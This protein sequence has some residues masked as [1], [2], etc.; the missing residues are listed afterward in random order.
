MRDDL[1]GRRRLDLKFDVA[2]LVDFRGWVDANTVCLPGSKYPAQV[3]S[4][5]SK[6]LF[7]SRQGAAPFRRSTWKAVLDVGKVEDWLAENRAQ[8]R[9]DSTLYNYACCILQASRFCFARLGLPLP[10]GYLDYMQ[11]KLRVLRRRRVNEEMFRLGQA[12]E[13]GPEDLRPLCRAVLRNSSCDDRMLQAVRAARDFLCHEVDCISSGDFLFAM[14]YAL[15]HSMVGSA[16]RP[17][18]LYTLSAEAMQSPAAGPWDG[19]TAVLLK[20]PLHKTAAHMGPC[21]LVVS[22]HGKKALFFYF[23]IVR[24][25]ALHCW[26]LDCEFVFCNTMGKGLNASTVTTHLA[27]I[28][29]Y[30]GLERPLVA[31][32]IRK[33]VTSQ[34]R[35][36][37][38]GGGDD[39]VASTVASALCHSVP[40]SNRYYL[41]GRGDRQAL[42][43]HEMVVDTILGDLE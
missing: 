13:R 18:A 41:L 2:L 36:R 1:A 23:F 14:R 26:G 25:A 24:R 4:T 9:S 35:L 38:P 42:Q 19:E 12:G 10:F 30:C 15:M 37:Q 33:A 40:T 17:S 39:S 7:F 27:A 34:L 32:D 20:N 22:G 21:R 3:V 11:A 16:A 43:F 6:Y 28:Q 5:V 29:R 8:R 31:T